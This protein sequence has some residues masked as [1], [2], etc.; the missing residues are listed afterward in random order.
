MSV[1][2]PSHNVCTLNF[3][4]KFTF[5]LPLH[6]DVADT[7]ERAFAK[8]KDIAPKDKPGIDEAYNK[9]LDIIDEVVGEGAAAD[10]MSIFENPG[11]LEVWEVLMFI[12]TEWKKA[13]SEAL[14]K[15]KASGNV[16]PVNRAERRA[17]R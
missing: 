2:R 14:E 5:E 1:F 17:R 11:T 4:D 7:F 13:Y 10:I 15:L 9:A 16:P 8:L 6:E 3:D 12:A